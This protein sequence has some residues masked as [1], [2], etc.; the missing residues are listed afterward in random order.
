MEKEKFLELFG[1]IEMV[2]FDI[3]MRKAIEI[4]KN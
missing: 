4:L 3:K 2:K 1:G